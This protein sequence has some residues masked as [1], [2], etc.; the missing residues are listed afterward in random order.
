M[1]TQRKFS[2]FYK[3]ALPFHMSEVP[4][5]GMCLSAFVVLQNGAGEVLLG[6]PSPNFPDWDNIGAL[7]PDRVARISEKWMLPSSHLVLHESPQEA[8]GRILKEQLG[9]DE[10]PLKLNVF[11]EVYDI[12]AAG[13]KNH[14]DLEFVFTG[15][16]DARVLARVPSQWKA[17]EFVQLSR[18]KTADFARNHQDILSHLGLWKESV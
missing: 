18:L 7:N 9:F 3:N 11:S 12:P 17:L 15:R 5:G 6:K 2:D 4:A 16:L 8:A 13:L 1:T 10:V 14:W